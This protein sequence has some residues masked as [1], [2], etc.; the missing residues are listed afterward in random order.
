MKSRC[1]SLRD[2]EHTILLTS[3]RDW[4]IFRWPF[5][6]ARW[7][8][9]RENKDLC[10]RENVQISKDARSIVHHDDNLLAQAPGSSRLLSVQAKRL[11]HKKHHGDAMDR[12]LQC[13]F[14]ESDMEDL[15]PSAS[16]LLDCCNTP[17]LTSSCGDSCPTVVMRYSDLHPAVKSSVSR[18]SFGPSAAA[19]INAFGDLSV[20][21]RD[22]EAQRHLTDEMDRLRDRQ[23]LAEVRAFFSSLRDFSSPNEAEL[24]QLGYTDCDL[25]YLVNL[26]FSVQSVGSRRP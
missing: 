25:S 23:L 15:L 13:H 1:A 3:T 22:A 24:V 6:R 20:S 14:D 18:D 4:Q 26:N 8:V 10:E 11:A 21:G 2:S 5:Q 9:A 19:P 16:D 12:L 17:D 7:T